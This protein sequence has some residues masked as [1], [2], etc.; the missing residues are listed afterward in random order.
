VLALEELLCWAASPSGLYCAARRPQL[1]QV[2]H[3]PR[4]VCQSD[5]TVKTEAALAA[6]ASASSV[7]VHWRPGPL[8]VVTC[9]QA[10]D[11]MMVPF[12]GQ[13]TLPHLA[14]RTLPHL[15]VTARA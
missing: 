6:G 2:F 9:A 12:G 11:S 1:R 13:W 5:P 3:Y 14:A 7:N 4:P 10:I 8:T 15:A